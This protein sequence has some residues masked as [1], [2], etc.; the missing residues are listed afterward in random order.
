MYLKEI[1]AHSNFGLAISLHNIIP[2]D[3]P[4]Y[5]QIYPRLSICET[6][7]TEGNIPTTRPVENA[8]LGK[9]E[10]HSNAEDQCINELHAEKNKDGNSG[11]MGGTP[12]TD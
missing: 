4:P 11:K 6:N 2:L 1:W 3:W 8:L 10:E 9:T 5:S 7:W 12:V